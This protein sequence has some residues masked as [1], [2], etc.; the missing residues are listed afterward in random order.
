MNEKLA[1]Q[2]KRVKI[3]NKLF[4]IPIKNKLHYSM[5]T[6]QIN[7]SIEPIILNNLTQN[8]VQIRVKFPHLGRQVMSKFKS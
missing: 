8:R 5:C 3:S 4:Q 6:K 1:S 7:V 2:S